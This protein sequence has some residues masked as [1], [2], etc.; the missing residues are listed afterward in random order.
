MGRG[1]RRLLL[2]VA[3]VIVKSVWFPT[4]DRTD[5][6]DVRRLTYEEAQALDGPLAIGWTYNRWGCLGLDIARSDGYFSTLRDGN[7]WGR[8]SDAQA[9]ELGL[10]GAPF[11][12]YL[13]PG[14]LIL[15]AALV[16]WFVGRTPRRTTVVGAIIGLHV[17]ASVALLAMGLVAHAAI[18]LGNVLVLGLYVWAARDGYVCFVDA[19]PPR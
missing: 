12:Y 5:T 14:L 1:T 6:I 8:L 13:P 19:V 17:V 10:D 9:E 2:I 3:L 11:G 7:A 16:L 18:P 4:G 15:V